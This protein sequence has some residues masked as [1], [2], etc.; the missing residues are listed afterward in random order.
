M[1]V[2]KILIGFCLFTIACSSSHRTEK[3]TN[4]VIR[5]DINELEKEHVPGTVDDVWVEPMY[6]TVKVPGTI[7]PKGMYFR[8]GHRAVIQVRQGKYQMQEYP[9]DRV[10]EK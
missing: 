7:D 9:D 8:K 6:D 1:K 2:N 5:P 4:I 3:V 10:G